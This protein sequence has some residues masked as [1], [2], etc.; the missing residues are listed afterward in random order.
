VVLVA[1]DQ[2]VHHVVLSGSG[3]LGR[4]VAPFDP[5]LFSP[6]QR[7]SLERVRVIVDGTVDGPGEAHTVPFDT[8]LGWCPQPGSG[9][10]EYRYDWAGCRIG[11]GELPRRKSP[12]VRR[13]VAVGCSFTHGDDVGARESWAA[14]VDHD[15]DELEL[16]NLGFGGYGLDQA[17]LRLQRDGLPL[18]PDEVWMGF[19][20]SAAPRVGTLYRPV[21]RHW[22]L[23]VGFKPCFSFVGGSDFQLIPNPARTLADVPRL[24]DD[25]EAFLDAVGMHDLWVRRA[26]WAY[27]PRGSHWTHHTATTRLALTLFERGKR[28]PEAWLRENKPIGHTQIRSVLR[29]IVARA[30]E[31]SESAGARFRFLV[32]PSE[33]DVR[34]Y[35]E[36][37]AYWASFLDD[38][39]ADGVEVID[40]T[41]VLATARGG[42]AELWLNGSHYTPAGHRLVAD[43]LLFA[44]R[45]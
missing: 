23:F 10:G 33:D 11:F 3:L 9:S 14:L 1:L 2:L 20:P 43:A 31:V 26:R 34:T 17:L 22:S 19:L 7:A 32:L 30:R 39:R 6:G 35:V 27:E 29:T 4:P 37:D 21:Q 38:L 41:K 44:A 40:V 42:K 28:D 16:A 45:R 18:E 12:G 36:G 8:E 24:L 5:P 13:I 15:T 25:Q